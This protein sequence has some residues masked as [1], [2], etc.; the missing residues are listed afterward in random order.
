MIDEANTD[1]KKPISI[2]LIS[3]IGGW[4]IAYV[5]EAN[6]DTCFAR[7]EYNERTLWAEVSGTKN[8]IVTY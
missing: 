8:G 5:D 7:A 6:E 4:E 3:T 1:N 2:E